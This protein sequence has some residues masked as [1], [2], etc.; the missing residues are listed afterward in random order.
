LAV[1]K[2]KFYGWFIA[3]TFGVYVMYDFLVLT[4]ARI[5]PGFL[6]LLFLAAS[7]SILYAVWQIYRRD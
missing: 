5:A 1:Q 4:E 2:M 3:F 7:I 6:A